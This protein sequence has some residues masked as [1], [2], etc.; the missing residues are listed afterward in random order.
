MIVLLNAVQFAVDTNKDLASL[1]MIETDLSSFNHLFL[2]GLPKLTFSQNVSEKGSRFIERWNPTHPSTKHVVYKNCFANSLGRDM[3]HAAKIKG[4]ITNKLKNLSSTEFASV[5]VKCSKIRSPQHL[6]GIFTEIMHEGR[7]VPLF[8]EKQLEKLLSSWLALKNIID[9]GVRVFKQ[10][11]ITQEIKLKKEI[12]S[13][14]EQLFVIQTLYDLSSENNITLEKWNSMDEAKKKRLCSLI[15][16]GNIYSC[17]KKRSEFE[18]R[19]FTQSPNKDELRELK[20]SVYQ[21]VK[22]DLYCLEHPSR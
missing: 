11:A 17:L 16:E 6:L 10:E 8:T 19:L 12:S 4:F 21:A 20:N 18:E 2:S 3:Y 13:N 7:R 15:S 5:E 1:K 22:E 9:E 14:E